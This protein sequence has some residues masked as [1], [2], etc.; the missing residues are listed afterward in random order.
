MKLK[1][2]ALPALLAG[3]FA[4]ALSACGDRDESA[5]SADSAATTEVDPRIESIFL[6]EEPEDAV[7][8]VEARKEVRP[9]SEITVVGRVAGAMEPFS[10]DYSTLV[11]ADKS[12]MTCEQNPDDAC[13]TPW[14]A[15]CVEPKTI[16]ASRVSV[17]VSSDEGRPVEQSLKGVNGLTELDEIVV[18]GTVNENST[19][20]NV[21]ID[22]TGI[23]RKSS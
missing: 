20:E 17:Q 22:A 14:D 19:A 11:L 7:S 9:G 1:T 10:E 5:D 12:L 13:E 2:P 18:T 8:V 16:A 21:V 15:C 23:F 3:A 6:D 4:L